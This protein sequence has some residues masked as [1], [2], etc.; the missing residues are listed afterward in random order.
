M[1][2]NFFKDAEYNVQVNIKT[3][4]EDKQ[5]TE[6]MTWIELHSVVSIHKT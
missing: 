4:F 1:W 2:W 3:D 5:V 6:Y